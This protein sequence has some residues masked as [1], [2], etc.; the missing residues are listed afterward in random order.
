MSTFRSAATVLAT[1][2]TSAALLVFAGSTA[3]AGSPGGRGATDGPGYQQPRVGAC[4]TITF[5]QGAAESNSTRPISCRRDHTVRTVEVGRLPRGVDWDASPAKLGRIAVRT[6][7]PAVDRALG[8]TARVRDLSAYNWFWF[9]PTRT[10]REHGARWLRCDL[11]LRT[12]RH[13]A[14]LPSDRRPVLGPLPLRERVARCLIGND[15]TST[16]CARRHDWRATGTFWMKGRYHVTAIDRAASHRCPDRVSSSRFQWT[17]RDETS[18]KLGD[19]VVVC[20]SRT[21]S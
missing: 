2:A 19:H 10:Q 3:D 5:D 7:R 20:Y 9:Q 6:C 1:L 18:W 14:D 17:Y 15:L 4:R 12:G 8:R 21:A 16:T 11:A 13:L